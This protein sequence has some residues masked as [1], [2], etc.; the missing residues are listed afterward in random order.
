[1]GKSGANQY[2]GVVL[3]NHL[4]FGTYPMTQRRSLSLTVLGAIGIV[5]AAIL[6][7]LDGTFLRPALYTLPTLLVVLLE[8]SLGFVVLIPWLVYHRRELRLIDARQWL[9]IA[10]IVVL[11]GALGTVFITKAFFL[12]NFQGLSIVIVLQKLQPVFAILLAIILLRERFPKKFY[13]LAAVALVAGYFVTFPTGVPNLTSGRAAALAALFALGAAASWGFSTTLGK[14][15]VR[16]IDSTLLAALRFG[17]TALL[18]LVVVSVTGAWALPSTTQWLTFAG[19]VCSSGA[20]AML[21][22]YYGL[23]KV[24]ASQATFYEL[25]WP[26]SAVVLDYIINGTR[27]TASQ[28]A[29][30]AVLVAVVIGISRLRPQYAPLTGTVIRGAGRGRFLGYATAN[31]SPSVA[32]TLTG[33]VYLADVVTPQ[34]TYVGLLHYGFNWFRGELTCEVLLKDFNG[35]LYDH[36]VTIFVREKI[37]EIKKFRGTEHAKRE[38]EH[39][40]RWLDGATPLAH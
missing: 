14:Y 30:G 9:A 2:T 1:M 29:A 15:A 36:T 25:A 18:M 26:V 35:D 21:L 23:K 7:S 34:G 39:D 5:A 27:L 37:R 20:V 17:L 28:L 22:Y 40:C 11:G 10:L 8:H 38:L 12:T 16:T 13:A 32:G 4:Y 24:A 19:I 3:Y 6:W 31:L 33:G